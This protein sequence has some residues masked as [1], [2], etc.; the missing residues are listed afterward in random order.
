M[1]T[2][3]NELLLTPARQD[4][5]PPMRILKSFKVCIALLSTV[6][7][8]AIPVSIVGC[9]GGC[10]TSTLEPGGAYAPTNAAGEVIF[11]EK[12]LALADATYKLTY[13]SALSVLAYERN[14]RV[15]I[16]ALSPE[17]KKAFD[18]VRPVVADID[19]RW[20]KARQAYKKNPTPEGLSLM[21]EIMG[22][23]DRLLPALQ[24]QIDPVKKTL[25]KK[26][27][28]TNSVTK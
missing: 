20:A 14:N 26:H 9:S 4:Y 13:E 15:A 24:T 12:G 18:K 3:E 5:V 22:E 23:I 8:L 11:D 28:S 2:G 16:W 19:L 17:V 10:K 6:A 7:V 25:L 27:A 1:S 21:Q